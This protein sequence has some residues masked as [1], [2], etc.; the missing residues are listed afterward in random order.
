MVNGI[1]SSFNDKLIVVLVFMA[2]RCPIAR[3]YNDRLKAIQAGYGSRGVQLVGINSDNQY[4]FPLESWD[5]D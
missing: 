5:N 2:N 3:V 4:F 1:L